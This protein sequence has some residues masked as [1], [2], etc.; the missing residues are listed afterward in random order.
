MQERLRVIVV[1][2]AAVAVRS[3]CR[4]YVIGFDKHFNMVNYF[5]NHPSLMVLLNNAGTKCFQL[6]S[7]VYTEFILV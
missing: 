1:V 2:R 5:Y 3:R 7:L 4:G 6:L